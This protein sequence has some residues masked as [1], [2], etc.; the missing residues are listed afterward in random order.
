MN[1][2]Q[3]QKWTVIREQGRKSYVVKRALLWGTVFSLWNALLLYAIR[4]YIG[5]P[6]FVRQ[7]RS[8]LGYDP[9]PRDTHIELQKFF[10]ETVETAGICL[11][12]AAF[13]AFTVWTIK[14]REY[15]SPQPSQ[16]T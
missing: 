14:E 9:S 1:A 3:I 13:L 15:R 4:F 6:L 16:H 10:L 12:L 5:P 8:L 7:F 11:L 2:R